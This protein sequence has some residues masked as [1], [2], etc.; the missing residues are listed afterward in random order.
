[1]V[2]GRAASASTTVPRKLSSDYWMQMSRCHGELISQTQ[3]TVHRI[4][5][6]SPAL[7]SAEPAKSGV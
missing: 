1:M 6:A 5:F 3:E 7:Q 2:G 4:T